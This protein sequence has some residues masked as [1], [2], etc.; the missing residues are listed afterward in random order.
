MVATEM[1][2]ISPL[3]IHDPTASNVSTASPEELV[4][5]P[6]SQDTANQDPIVPPKQIRKVASAVSFALSHRRS[7][8]SSASS[9]RQPF[10]NDS[11]TQ[12]SPLRRRS[13]FMAQQ[14]MVDDDAYSDS[15]SSSEQIFDNPPAIA[16]IDQETDLRVRMTVGEVKAIFMDWKRLK[17]KAEEASDIDDLANGE[18]TIS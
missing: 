6:N 9:F 10:V 7:A 18:V 5:A 16:F 15:S 12:T 11:P 17:R 3:N 4:D 1:G 8:G 13:S 2:A 14:G